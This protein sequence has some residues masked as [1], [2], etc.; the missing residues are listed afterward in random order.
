[1]FVQLSIHRPKPEAT[2]LLIESMHAYGD[3]L[4]GA[5]GLIS[6]KTLQDEDAGVLV[7]LALWSSRSAM[8]ESV[9]LA[10]AAVEDHPFD[11]WEE[12]ETVGYRLTEV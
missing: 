2:S 7:G 11:Q 9:H 8:E 10:R 6:V 12:G 1:M 4:E 3:A 5:P